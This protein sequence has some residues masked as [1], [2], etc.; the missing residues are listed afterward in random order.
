[1]CFANVNPADRVVPDTHGVSGSG[2]APAA[3]P[4]ADRAP[5]D[6][7]KERVRR[8]ERFVSKCGSDSGDTSRVRSAPIWAAAG[9]HSG[10][11]WNGR[12][13]HVPRAP[14]ICAVVRRLLTQ[15]SATHRSRVGRGAY[16]RG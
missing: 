9:A 11:A 13:G 7:T 8:D 3:R 15:G 2:A 1:G 5:P 16:P 14:G 12:E 4:Q 10:E 6:S